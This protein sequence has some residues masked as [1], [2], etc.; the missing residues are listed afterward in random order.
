MPESV[1]FRPRMP[2]SM[3]FRPRMLSFRM[4]ALNADADDVDL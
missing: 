4:H 3:L 2:N 1:L